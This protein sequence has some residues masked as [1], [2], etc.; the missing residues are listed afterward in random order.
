MKQGLKSKTILPV[1]VIL[2][3]VMSG[4]A[5]F[6]YVSQV[7]LLTDEAEET[8]KGVLNTAHGILNARMDL[9]QQ[10]ATLVAGMP[11]AAD[12]FGKGER[13]KLLTEFSPGFEILKK[14]FGLAQFQFHTPPA[15]SFL[16]VHQPEKYGDDLSSFRFTVLS[17][18]EKRAG[19]R[20]IEI[21]RAGIGLRGVEPV[22]SKG[23]HVGSVEFGGELGPAL[24]DAKKVFNTDVTVLISQE[25]ATQVWQEWQKSLKPVG[26]YA[27]FYSTNPALTQGIIRHGT[28]AAAKAAG[29]AAYIEHAAAGGREYYIAV[30][31][32]TDFSGKE[33]GFL[34]I[35]MD[36]TAVVAKIR[37]TLAINLAVYASILAL[38]SVVINISLRKTV[39]SPVI[40]LTN[41]ADAVSMG[42]LADKIEIKSNDE[43][44]TLAKSL[45]RMRVSMKKLLE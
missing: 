18:N 7:S 12:S 33:V 25:A 35:L 8:L 17:V 43:L 28:L 9:Y 24:E 6:N 27:P 20:G 37:R 30:S 29:R 34:G 13:K 42:K 36:R 40:A 16:R 31:P 19:V 26:N 44:E 22:F 15:M 5:A 41:A 21:G 32:L 45:D 11:S 14:K 38:V 1:M 23:N 2:V 39:I 4:L 3:L 10:M